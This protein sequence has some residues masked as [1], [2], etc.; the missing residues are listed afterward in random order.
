MHKR[1]NMS[2]LFLSQNKISTRNIILGE[3]VVN[4][5]HGKKSIANEKTIG[6]IPLIFDYFMK[7]HENSDQNRFKLEVKLSMLEVEG[8]YPYDLLFNCRGWF[9]SRLVYI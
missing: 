3:N 9:I 1:K 8:N 6:L 7:M 5:F 2:M 4:R